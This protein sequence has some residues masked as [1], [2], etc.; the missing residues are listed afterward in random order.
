[1]EDAEPQLVGVIAVDRCNQMHMRTVGGVALDID[2]HRE[3]IHGVVP[4]VQGLE[5]SGH[6][7]IA[8][9]S[10]LP[11]LPGSSWLSSSSLKAM[12]PN[13]LPG[14]RMTGSMAMKLR[15]AGLPV[16]GETIPTRIRPRGPPRPPATADR[17]RSHLCDPRSADRQGVAGESTCDDWGGSGECW[18]KRAVGARRTQSGDAQQQNPLR[19]KRRLPASRR[20][21]FEDHLLSFRAGSNFTR[22][23]ASKAILRHS[24]G[25]A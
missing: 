2:G 9:Q 16:S 19:D 25:H 4:G 14:P 21:R 17:R 13:R 1:M 18:A 8:T 10:R 6:R 15:S 22:L 7:S 3:P 5:G 12:R 20:T 11:R 24:A 23:S